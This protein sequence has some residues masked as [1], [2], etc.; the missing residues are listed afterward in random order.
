ML[1][2]L[3]LKTFFDF[4]DSYFEPEVACDAP[5]V[6]IEDIFYFPDSYFEPE[7]G[8]DATVVP[9][10]EAVEWPELDKVELPLPDL[11]CD[12]VEASVA[13]VSSE[14]IL[15][16]MQQE[17]VK[18]ELVEASVA[19]VSRDNFVVPMQ[20][21]EVKV[22]VLEASVAPVS[23]D[24]FVVPM[25]QVDV[26]VDLVEACVA[27]VVDVSEIFNF[28]DEFF[29]EDQADEV[30]SGPVDSKPME[31]SDVFDFADSFFE[32]DPVFA[33]AS[34]AMP[35]PEQVVVDVI[36]VKEGSMSPKSCRQSSSVLVDSDQ[37]FLH[38][39]SKTTG[40]FAPVCDTFIDFL[41]CL[42][43]RFLLFVFFVLEFSMCMFKF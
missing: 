9:L 22:E 25:Q 7:V 40:R 15:V 2:M 32:A 13:P 4:S 3:L 36:L 24:N 33:S 19:P 30:A 31:L 18:V 5:V 6:A 39:Y 42:F 21:V 11:G 41:L 38:C 20:Q 27:P 34:E 23:S 12:V 10:A 35:E 16:P 29:V 43:P 28:S 8:C 14:E 1:Q 17:E 26:K 37:R